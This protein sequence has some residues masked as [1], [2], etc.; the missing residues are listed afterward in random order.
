MLFI[1]NRVTEVGKLLSISDNVLIVSGLENTY[2][3][4]VVI[5]SDG[6]INT[7]A[8]GLVMTLDLNTVKVILTRG[9]QE[10]ITIGDLVIRTERMLI[11]ISGFGIL[12]RIIN[13][14]GEFILADDETDENW[15]YDKLFA[16]FFVDM[17]R[18]PPGVSERQTI[19]IP[20]ITGVTAVDCFIPIGLGQ[21]ELI[22]GDLNTGKT[23]LAITMVINQRFYINSHDRIWRMLEL[24]LKSLR[25]SVRFTP[26]IY[27]LAGKRRSEL[28]RLRNVLIRHNSLHYTCIVFAGCDTLASH[29]YLAPYAGMA[30]G[31]WFLDNAYHA[32]VVMDDLS[33]QAVAYRQISLLLRRPPGREAYPGDI[34]FIHSRLLERSTFAKKNVGAGSITTI[35]IVETKM[36]DIS[37]YIPTNVISI[38]DGQL[39]LS[40]VMLNKGIKPAIHLGFSVSRVGSKAQYDCMREISKFIKYD[41]TMYREYESLGKV[42]NDLDSRIRSFIDK[43]LILISFLNQ[44]LYHGY[45]FFSEV[46]SLFLIHE[47]YLDN[48]NKK[49][50]HIYFLI[51]LRGHF[52]SIYLSNYLSLQ[53]YF[54]VEHRELMESVL[55]ES[56]IDM[57][58]DDFTEIGCNYTE[59]FLNTIQPKLLNDTKKTYIRSLNVIRI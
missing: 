38:T 11:T 15:V 42:S 5:I 44:K 18:V 56:D 57:Y 17:F 51:L 45:S 9:S 59:F 22:L 4:E 8:E 33:E 40:R 21:R 36:G 2:V 26:C 24:K 1:R 30:M 47:G 34:F 29:V 7:K 14:L 23:S 13:P 37:A 28:I 31:E 10:S 39:F 27:V 53:K 52:T 54:L 19:F 25:K 58:Y 16:L 55:I 3:G 12:S 46:L 43:G 20:F 35:P 50:L 48:V 41:Y 6:S 32:I 49:F